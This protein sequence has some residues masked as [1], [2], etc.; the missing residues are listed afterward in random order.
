MTY[1]LSNIGHR[2]AL[3]RLARARGQGLKSEPW[4]H[5]FLYVTLHE[6]VLASQDHADFQ[7]LIDQGLLQPVPGDWDLARVRQRYERNPL[8]NVGRI[9]FEMTSR[10]NL[11]CKHCR[12]GV[13]KRVTE[14]N[15]DKLKDAARLFLEMGV[16]RFDFI[17]GE[18]TRYAEGWLDLCRFIQDFGR[19]LFS[20]PLVITVY[21]SGWWLE[22]QDFYAAGPTYQSDMQFLQDMKAHGLSHVVFSVDGPEALHDD[23]RQCPGLYQRILRGFG[24]VRAAGLT[25]QVSTVYRPEDGDHGFVSFARELAEHLYE[26]PSGPDGAVDSDDKLRRFA[27]DP[28]NHI[29]NFIDINN[30]VQL[31]KRTQTLDQIADA[32]IRCK[33]FYRPAPTMRVMA[34]GELGICPLMNAAEGYGNIH[35]RPLRDILNS[36][37]ESLLFQLHASREIEKMRAHL[38]RSVFGEHFDHVCSLRTVLNLLA[39]KMHDRDIDPQDAE[40]MYSLNLEVARIT[41]HLQ[42]SRLTV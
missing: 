3:E 17:G 4:G 14:T 29:S 11:H 20:R 28:L 16:R 27:A 42:D 6:G 35:E 2:V 25:P 5:K 23:W 40:A 7:A 21:T 9:N 30:A 36:L 39:R 19:D 26:F 22:E 8:E 33:A 18:V 10:C 24:K 15:I 13:V 1:M 38:D 34:S 31:R 37:Q 32:Q 12:S 41:G